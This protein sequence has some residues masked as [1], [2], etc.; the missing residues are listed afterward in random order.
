MKARTRGGFGAVCAA[1]ALGLA[2]GCTPYESLP[3]S[4]G[5]AGSGG[6]GDTTSST[7]EG[8]GGS[9]AEVAGAGG[10]DPDEVVVKWAEAVS[11]APGKTAEVCAFCPPDHP[12]PMSGGFEMVSQLNIVHESYPKDWSKPDGWESGNPAGWCVSAENEGGEPSSF[13]A[14]IACRKPTPQL[15]PATL[16]LVK[17]ETTAQWDGLGE[18]TAMAHCPEGHPIPWAGGFAVE[19]PEVAGTSFYPLENMPVDWEDP[20]AW[21]P[22]EPNPAKWRTKVQSREAGSYS[23]TVGMVCGTSGHV[24]KTDHICASADMSWEGEWAV[25]KC[26]PGCPIPVM[27][28]VKTGSV[29]ATI[30]A[31]SPE[32]WDIVSGW[33]SDESVRAGWNGNQERFGS[34]D[35][36][37]TSYLLC[38]AL[39]TSPALET[40]PK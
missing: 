40:L 35:N 6:A 32:R 11:V 26:A 12:V 23:L 1:M 31:S 3:G 14:Y 38:R 37:D 34:P 39:R 9:G 2:S 4:G 17:V 18:V 21:Y 19:A 7:S 13:N 24:E 28:G 20:K 16:D 22:P 36:Q 30:N 10:W 27:G 25:A 5:S 15:D 33:G 8:T 29:N